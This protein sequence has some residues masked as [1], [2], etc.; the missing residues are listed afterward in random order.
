MI[1][2]MLMEKM[3][4]GGSPL[5]ARELVLTHRSVVQGVLRLDRSLGPTLT[6]AIGRACLRVIAGQ[7]LLFQHQ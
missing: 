3:K 7:D 1:T 2:T 5:V 6:V 4:A